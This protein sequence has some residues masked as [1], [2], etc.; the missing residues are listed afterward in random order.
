M[1]TIIFSIPGDYHT[2]AVRWAL[3]K[4][5]ASCEVI[6]AT[7]L[8]QKST[9]TIIC[10]AAQFQIDVDTAKFVFEDESDISSIWYRRSGNPVL[11]DSLHQ[12]DVVPSRYSWL[13]VING[14]HTSFCETDAMLVNSPARYI[15]CDNKV[16]QLLH[17]TRIGFNLPK[18]IVSNDSEEIIRFIKSLSANGFRTICKSFN[19]HSW[20]TS[21]GRTEAFG[22]SLVSAEDIV[23]ADVQS[24]PNIYQQYIEKI[25]EVRICAIGKN[26]FAAKI[27]SQKYEEASLDFRRIGDTNKLGCH[28][29]CIPD[30]VDRMCKRMLEQFGLN[31]GSFDFVVDV[32]GNWIF[33]ELNEMGNFLWL[34]GANPEIP[35]LDCFSEFLISGDSDF[36]YIAKPNRIR[37]L[38]FRKDDLEFD[39]VKTEIENNITPRGYGGVSVEQ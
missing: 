17:A 1:R 11:K 13:Q 10:D 32:D 29:L 19:P 5:G 18:T 2:E 38:D 4:K 39:L 6:Y 22:T 35:L 36:H 27:D 8:A 37:Y 26:L 34:E 23:K 21:D 14:I 16:H 33:L 3:R 15:I 9:M 24:A 28:T 20:Y 12:A 7:N 31:H 30:D 25:F